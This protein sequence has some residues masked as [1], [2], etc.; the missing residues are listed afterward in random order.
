MLSHTPW[1]EAPIG[2]ECGETKLQLDV[3]SGEEGI[4]EDAAWVD[5]QFDVKFTK[6]NNPA[7]FIEVCL[8][9][10]NRDL[11]FFFQDKWAWHTSHDASQSISI[12][13]QSLVAIMGKKYTI[14]GRVI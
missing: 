10:P 3:E 4:F 1:Y 7:D 2:W 6:R 9:G 13:H 12:G 5:W 8:C 11:Y 14:F